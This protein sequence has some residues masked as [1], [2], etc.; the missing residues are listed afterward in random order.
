MADGANFIGASS[1]RGAVSE[2]PG[3]P[4]EIRELRLA[5]LAS[6]DV[7][8]RIQATSLCHTDL[9]AVD[10]Q[11]DTPLPFVPGHEAAGIVE[12]TGSSVYRLSVGDH[13]ALS[14]NPHCGHCYFCSHEQFILCEQYRANGVRSV[15]FDG[16]ARIFDGKQPVH[17]L[18][19]AGT[20]AELAV[21]TEDC[22]VR[23]PKSM[24]FHVACLIGCGVATGI[25]AVSNIARVQPRSSVT[26]IGCGAVGLSAIQGARLAQAETI[27][28]IDRDVRKLHMAKRLGA[29]HTLPVDENLIQSHAALTCGRGADYV[30]EAAGN[31]RGF[32]TSLEIVRPGGQVVWL[33]K[34]AQQQR[35]S[36]RWGSL[37]GEKNI[38]RSSYGGSRAQEFFPSLAE[39]YL[40]GDLL[41][42]DYVTSRISLGEVNAALDRLRKGL[43]IRSVIEF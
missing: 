15:H 9:E 1:M 2:K 22:A 23:I 36:F 6:D 34:V 7:I 11:L 19:Y 12:W 37:M 8:V 24:P 41:L 43:D 35:V 10:G 3:E 16:K 28:A 14:W 18:M 29:T 5:N 30:F 42:D 40:S 20:F 17:Q 27:I 38:V 4:L 33:G 13:V 32:Q 21:V 39:K 25:G 26:I 31:E